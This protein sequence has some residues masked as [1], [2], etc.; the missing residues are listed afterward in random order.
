M[1]ALQEY[2]DHMQQEYNAIDAGQPGH[3]L[4]RFW[5]VR[6]SYPMPG[7]HTLRYGGNTACVEVQAGKHT[8]ILDAGSGII[9]LGH[10]LLQRSPGNL[11]FTLLFTHSHSDHLLGL[12]FFA[13]LFEGRALLHLFGPFQAERTMEQLITPLMSSPYFPVDIR[14]L[15]SIRLFHTLRHGDCLVWPYGLDTPR[16]ES[17]HTRALDETEFRVLSHYTSHHG[18][19]GIMMY[20]I[21][22]AGHSLVYCTDVEWGNHYPPACTAFI[23]G[24]DVLIHDAQYTDEDYKKGR[25]GFGHSSIKMATDMARLADVGTLIL[26]HH[27]PCYDDDKLDWME[28]RARQRFPS[29]RSAY[30]GMEVNLLEEGHSSFLAYESKR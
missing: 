1:A 15:P 16:F 17:S 29:T 26:F 14:T 27:D 28:A 11:S 2:G 4:V 24:A 30:E 8:L 18:P 6:G 13:P 9:H 20:R 3:F 10:D 25:Y 23:R 7:P 22:Y 5:G 21:E 19:D 12:P